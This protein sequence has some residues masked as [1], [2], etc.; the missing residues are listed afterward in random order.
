MPEIPF[1][2]HIYFKHFTIMLN[3]SM[4]RK[5]R[6]NV[7]FNTGVTFISRKR[8]FGPFQQQKM[9]WIL[10]RWTTFF[11][12]DTATATPPPP[13]DFCIS[14]NKKKYF[15]HRS[16]CNLSLPCASMQ[17][18]WSV[19]N[20]SGENCVNDQRYSNSIDHQTNTISNDFLF[21]F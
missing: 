14:V 15:T 19:N 16:K 7:Y 20:A 4:K 3:L 11:C 8:S 1:L 18:R 21:F 6:E 2:S 17:Y 12:I 10:V 9:Y 5:A 13:L